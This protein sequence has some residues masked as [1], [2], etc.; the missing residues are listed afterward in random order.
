MEKKNAV[1]V[2]NYAD[3]VAKV[4]SDPYIVYCKD[5]RD[6]EVKRLG[7]NID[8]IKFVRHWLRVAL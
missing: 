3:V 2:G 4:T 5:F 8:L 6:E 1:F 7:R